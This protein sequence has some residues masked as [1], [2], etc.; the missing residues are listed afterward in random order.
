MQKQNTKSRSR[1]RKGL[2]NPP[3][4]NKAIFDKLI[5]KTAKSKVKWDKKYG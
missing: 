4:A 2:A 5:V 3:I 1:K